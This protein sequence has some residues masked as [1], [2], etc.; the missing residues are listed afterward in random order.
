[1]FVAH[2][3]KAGLDLLCRLEHIRWRLEWIKLLC[4]THGCHRSGWRWCPERCFVGP[5]ALSS[6]ASCSWSTGSSC[7]GAPWQRL[8]LA[9]TR[10]LA[11]SER[12]PVRIPAPGEAH[13]SEIR[14]VAPPWHRG[15]CYHNQLTKERVLIAGCARATFTGRKNKHNTTPECVRRER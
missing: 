7:L 8:T 6:P 10:N 5:A 4:V 2:H 9:Q 14:A 12:C 15:G 1:M 3:V 11:G 13:R